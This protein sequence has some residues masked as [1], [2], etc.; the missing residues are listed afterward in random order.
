MRVINMCVSLTAFEKRHLCQ[1]INF[2]VE[3][4]GELCG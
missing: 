1:E 3:S 2:N 4:Q